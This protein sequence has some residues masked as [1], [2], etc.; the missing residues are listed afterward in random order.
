MIFDIDAFLATLRFYYNGQPIT[1]LADI[2]E[3]E[4]DKPIDLEVEFTGG[5][6]KIVLEFF[7]FLSIFLEFVISVYIWMGDWGFVL[8]VCFV[9]KFWDECFGFFCEYGRKRRIY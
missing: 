4:I 1:C 7:Y 9:W 5:W 2:N 6:L 3:Q 8:F